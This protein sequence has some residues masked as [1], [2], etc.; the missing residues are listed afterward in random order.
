MQQCHQDA[1][2]WRA[3]SHQRAE[4]RTP[5]N[6]LNTS[7]IKEK[8]SVYSTATTALGGTAAAG[9]ASSRQQ[10]TATA[11]IVPGRPLAAVGGEA[12]IARL[13]KTLGA[14]EHGSGGGRTRGPAVGAI[15]GSVDW[16]IQAN[17]EVQRLKQV[18]R[19]D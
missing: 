6:S 11:Q 19:C 12:D 17:A 5:P 4:S 7:L 9:S 15:K 18:C 13:D 8:P 2:A 14:S 16:A 10:A 1:R 3:A